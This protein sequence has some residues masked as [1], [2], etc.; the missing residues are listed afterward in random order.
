MVKHL[1]QFLESLKSNLP[2]ICADKDLIE[3]LPNIFRNTSNISRMRS[4]GQ[5]PSYFL[6]EPHVHYL[7]DDVINWFRDKYQIKDDLKET[8]ILCSHK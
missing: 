4:R 1:N 6:I 8:E 2:P 5:I 3:H 7:R